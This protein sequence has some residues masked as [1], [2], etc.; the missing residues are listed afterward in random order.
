MCLGDA[1]GHI[2]HV[3][4]SREAPALQNYAQV[5]AN[6]AVHS[7]F[8]KDSASPIEDLT[9]Y[10]YTDARDEWRTQ[11]VIVAKNNRETPCASA[12]QS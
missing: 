9:P 10:L 7:V 12:A 4:A 8:G 1:G 2:A 5:T 6:W 11:L 3:S